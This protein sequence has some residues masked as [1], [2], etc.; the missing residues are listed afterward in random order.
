MWTGLRCKLVKDLCVN[1]Q[2]EIQLTWLVFELPS[3]FFPKVGWCQRPSVSCSAETCRHWENRILICSVSYNLSVCFKNLNS[4]NIGILIAVI[5]CLFVYLRSECY[6]LSQSNEAWHSLAMP[7]LAP[8][9]TCWGYPNFR[10][11]LS[12]RAGSSVNRILL[13]RRTFSVESKECSTEAPCTILFHR[14]MYS[15]GAIA[16]CP[17]LEGL[18]LNFSHQLSEHCFSLSNWKEL[19]LYFNVLLN[20]ELSRNKL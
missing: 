16:T 2:P 12:E 17:T 3:F 18:T 4:F 20:F 11:H 6:D 10:Y 1:R 13:S 19:F 8:F 9:Q 15:L 14:C 7:V 5:F